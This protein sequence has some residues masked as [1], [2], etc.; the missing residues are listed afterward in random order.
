[1]RNKAGVARRHADND[2]SPTS[3]WK[4]L[5]LYEEPPDPPIPRIIT[6][7]TC[8]SKSSA[9]ANSGDDKK[10]GVDGLFGLKFLVEDAGDY[11]SE[12]DRLIPID[13][14]K[15][16]ETTAGSEPVS[17]PEAVECE[18]EQ[19]RDG[20]DDDDEYHSTKRGPYTLNR[21]AARIHEETKSPTMF[22]RSGS[23]ED[24]VDDG[25]NGSTASTARN[26]STRLSVSDESKLSQQQQL[27]QDEQQGRDTVSQML[28][29][30]RNAAASAT[31]SDVG[32]AP[33]PPPPQRASKPVLTNLASFEEGLGVVGRGNGGRNNA[34]SAVGT[35]PTFDDGSSYSSDRRQAWTRPSALR[36]LLLQGK[37]QQ[38]RRQKPVAA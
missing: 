25:C 13:L 36:N 18:D 8:S 30:T 5:T 10:R 38:Q 6:V 34:A 35:S 12:D 14:L 7:S 21:W 26:S 3:M 4:D 32:G 19:M 2:Q 27:L 23:T 29:W 15:E 22:G 33:P 31:S 17:E 24:H 37:D 1:M 16:F 9:S 20:T 11:S 28:A